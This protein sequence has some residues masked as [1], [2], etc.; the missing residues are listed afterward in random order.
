MKEEELY[1]DEAWHMFDSAG[2]GAVKEV[3]RAREGPDCENDPAG[4]ATNG[5]QHM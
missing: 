5:G 2:K 1:A 3:K 4:L